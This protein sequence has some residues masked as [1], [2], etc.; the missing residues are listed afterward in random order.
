MTLM[1]MKAPVK[2]LPA[3]PYTQMEIGSFRAGGRPCL[4]RYRLQVIMLFY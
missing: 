4:T 2:G 1:P 3:F